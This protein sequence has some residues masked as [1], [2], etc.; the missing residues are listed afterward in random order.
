MMCKAISISISIFFVRM[1]YVSEHLKPHKIISA[2]H[3]FTLALLLSPIHA[4]HVH[5]QKKYHLNYIHAKKL[6]TFDVGL[7][8]ACFVLAISAY[9]WFTYDPTISR[10]IDIRISPEI[11]NQT[12]II[13]SGEHLT[14]TAIV[15]NNAPIAL[16]DAVLFFE[17]PK[18]FI[19]EDGSFENNIDI[20]NTQ[21]TRTFTIKGYLL[22]PV[23]NEHHVSA[24]IKYRQ[25]NEKFF[26]E[27]IFTIIQNLRG[28]IVL[29]KLELPK[30]TVL[31]SPTPFTLSITNDN[32]EKIDKIVIPLTQ[33]DVTFVA[34]KDHKITDSEW[35]IENL[36][37]QETRTLS[38][39]LSVQKETVSN[40]FL[41]PYIVSP[42]NE[43]VAQKNV[44]ADISIVTPAL[45]VSSS[46]NDL[47]PMNPADERELTI[48]MKNTGK[49]TLEN[50]Q[51][52]I[53][54][55]NTGISLIRLTSENGGV[56]K[57]GTYTLNAPFTTLEPNTERSITLRIDAPLR[58]DSGTN[59]SLTPD[60]TTVFTIA[61]TATQVRVPV[62]VVP[63]PIG[64]LLTL[65]AESRYYTQEGDQLG[66]G[67]LPPIVGQETKYWALITISNSTNNIRNLNFSAIL[68]NHVSFTGRASVSHDGMPAYNETNRKITWSLPQ[69]NAH[70][71]AGIYM[72]LALTPSESQAG[73]SPKLL[74]SISIS[75]QDDFTGTQ[76]QEVSPALDTTIP[77][78]DIGNKKGVT[79]I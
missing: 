23:E 57:N 77:K 63:I 9:F 6:F 66:R 11:T 48:R 42:N 39:M 1:K 15:T 40:I 8:L 52:E 56:I 71:T 19:L 10:F 69:L 58:V 73:T 67:P 31:N 44:S 50:I 33:K 62:A 7:L 25:E 3:H 49:T 53:P 45:E 18:G 64:T 12:G 22:E 76:I 35:V 24:V 20:L 2:P 36:E 26:E 41:T 13:R 32:H 30:S 75:A 68:P 72:E 16:H 47:A 70:D 37:P 14:Y 54:L 65:S 59:I 78:D 74:E 43:R 28:S 60:P 61:N 27:K 46:W 4:F 5:Y 21:E 79:V 29:G 17:M 51:I 34:E 55:A 38:G